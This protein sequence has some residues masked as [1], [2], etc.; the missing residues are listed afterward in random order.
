M[1]SQLEVLKQMLAGLEE[2]RGPDGPM[3]TG[4]RLQIRCL[5]NRL[6]DGP[7]PNPVTM[8]KR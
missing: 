3:A 6:I 8:G 1:P 5:E 7:Q 4:L 2:R